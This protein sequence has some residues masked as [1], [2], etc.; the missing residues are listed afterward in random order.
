[1][2]RA[3]Q[4]LVAAG[5]VFAALAAPAA[6][7]NGG[8]LPGV[9]QGWDGVARGDVRYVAIPTG[10]QTVVQVIKRSS[11][12]VL[13]WTFV[14]GNFGIPQVAFDG[15]TDGLSRDGR[16]LV[17]ED[18]AASQTLTK[19]TTFAVVD[20]R[21]FRLRTTIKLRGDFAFDA[22][23]PGARMLY[24]IERLSAD[25]VLKYRVRA[26]DLGARRLVPKAVID[27]RS[28][29]SEMQGMPLA[30]ASS[31]DGRWAYTLYG[32]GPHP[33]VHALNTGGGGAFC[34]DLPH[35]W[36][37]ADTASMRLRTAPGQRLLVRHR[38]GGRALAVLDVEKFRVVRVVRNP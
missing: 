33:F 34:I 5:L 7:G 9:V 28:Q 3:T 8:P 15:T 21:R 27:K 4:L 11:G 6:S 12:R 37:D 1:M 36:S 29:E 22:L 38:S 16:T 25:D 26:Y 17:L 20:V 31:S 30:R 10:E 19:S 13:R 14:E 32:G 24:L 18:V 2:H 23:S 35:S